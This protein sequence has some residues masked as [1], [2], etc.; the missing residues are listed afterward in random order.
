MAARELWA[1]PTHTQQ[2]GSPVGHRPAR[3]TKDATSYDIWVRGHTVYVEA[4][5]LSTQLCDFG[6]PVQMTAVEWSAL[7]HVEGGSIFNDDLDHTDI[8][9]QQQIWE[10]RLKDRLK[11]WVDRHKGYCTAIKGGR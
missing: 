3:A 7:T 1:R 11:L 10:Q 8:S 2:L 6:E 4:D 9:S 5:E